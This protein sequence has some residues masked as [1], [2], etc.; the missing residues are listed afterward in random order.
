MNPPNALYAMF[1]CRAGHDDR[2]LIQPGSSHVRL[3]QYNIQGGRP[4]KTH[5]LSC[6]YFSILH[7]AL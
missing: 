3:S 1:E 5:H 6:L 7:G 2:P 4:A